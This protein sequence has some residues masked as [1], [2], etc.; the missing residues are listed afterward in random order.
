LTGDQKANALAIALVSSAILLLEITFTRILSVVLWY[1]FA[2]LSVSLAMLGLGLPGVWFALKP[3]GERALTVSLLAGAAAIPLGLLAILHLGP[4]L[5]WVP[6]TVTRPADLAGTRVILAVVCVLLPMLA[7]GSAVVLLLLRARGHAFARTY[8]ADLAG[9]SVGAAVAIPLMHL[10]PTPALVALAGFLPLF[11]LAVLRGPRSKAVWG[12]GAALCALLVWNQPLHLRYNKTYHEDGLLLEKWTPTARISVFSNVF[13][14]RK[15]Q[16]AFGW[17]MG[18]QFQPYPIQQ[19]WM[20]QDGSAG[21]PVTKIDRPLTAFPHLMYDVTSV[22]YQWRPPETV[23][24]IGA[25]GGRDVLTALASGARSVDA[26]ELNGAIVG[27][28]R[29]RFR[30]YCGNLYERPDVHVHV[31]EGRAYLTRARQRWDLIQ[32]SLID[33]FSA[34]ATGAFA[35]SENNL[36]TVEAMRLYL[37][38]LTPKGVLSVSRWSRLATGLE[39]PR[40]VLLVERALLQEGVAD[41]LQH[42]AVVEGGAL[43]TVLVSPSPITPGDL[44]TL[45]TLCVDKGFVRHWPRTASTPENSLIAQVLESGPDRYAKM[46]FDLSPPTDDRPFFFQLVHVLG[47]VDPG[48]ARSLSVNDGAVVLLRWLMMLV[49]GLA[50]LLFFLPFA[51]AGRLPKDPGFWRG[52]GYFAAI[53]LAFILVETAFIQRFILY[54]GHPSHATTVVLTAMLLGAGGG[55]FSALRVRP[56]WVDRWGFLLPVW[57]GFL[58]WFL[59][60]F[61]AASIGWSF[62]ARVAATLVLLL[63]VAFL[64]GFAFPVG[65]ACFG[66]ASKAWFWALNGVNGV[67]AGVLS[68]ALAMQ[69]G[70]DGVLFAGMGGYLLAWVLWR[71]AIR[72][73]RRASVGRESGAARPA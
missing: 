45:D 37:R 46:G 24:V 66:D 31:G 71:S 68:L 55:S 43:A 50:V 49:G 41:P 52:S 10:L 12:L 20:E 18:T 54:L 14:R 36:Y 38:R 35:L 34:T 13:W 25:G 64:M 4:L 27:L 40:L 32:L 58:G 22:G 53:G 15:P 3:P 21:T 17:G 65:M 7:L 29:G 33:S 72:L 11:A 73:D 62:A 9:A 30:V 26:V 69:I 67:L 70:F 59:P 60:G 1:H 44:A 19:L 47:R 56:G 42:L 28:L 39:A 16:T 63:P 5:P 51:W 57:V 61:F 8:A 48:L 6:G 23:C 2:F